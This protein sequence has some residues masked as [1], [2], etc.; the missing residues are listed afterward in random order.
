MIKN[1]SVTLIYY[2]SPQ[3][4]FVSH[5]VTE[6]DVRRGAVSPHAPDGMESFVDLAGVV[7]C[8][9]KCA[10]VTFYPLAYGGGAISAVP[11][12]SWSLFKSPLRRST[13]REFR[14][15]VRLNFL[16]SGMLGKIPLQL[17]KKGM[18]V[19]YLYDS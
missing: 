17:G 9:K 3:Y 12:Y 18:S 11:S 4:A 15:V 14:R 8:V 1:P 2:V 6:T 5:E 10:I 13:C 7:F 16:G 19:S